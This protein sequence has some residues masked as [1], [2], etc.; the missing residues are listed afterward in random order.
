M[1]VQRILPLLLAIIVAC[2][3][4]IA[5]ACPFCD[6]LPRTLSDDLE[7]SSAAVVAHPEAVSTEP[8]GIRVY[9]M[10]ITDVLKGAPALKNSVV[11]VTSAREIS[12]AKNFWLVG[13]G[14]DRLQ[15]FP[16]TA[17]TS[18]G[19][20]YLR[21]LS[22]LPESGPQRLEY[23]LRF[24]QHTEDFIAADA[25]NEFAE[26]S[27]KDIKG[28]GD[29]LSR[30]WVIAQLRDTAVPLHRRR[31]CWTFLSQCGTAQDT[32]LFDDALRKRRSDPSFNPGMDAAISCFISLGGEQA[33][34]RIEQDFL[35]NP[36]TKES[37]CFS[38][39]SAIRVHGTEL[40]VIP[41]ER[42]ATALRHLLARPELADLVIPD[43]SRWGDWSAIDRMVE[44]FQ[45]STEETALLKP[46]AVRYLKTCPLPD[47]TAALEKL[48]AIDGNAVQVA[49]ASMRFNLGRASLP[50]PPPDLDE[51]TLNAN[52]LRAPEV[53][54]QS[55][56]Q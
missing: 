31:L 56:G 51:P 8:D 39:V 21:G 38:A 30:D 53:A 19:I 44:L 27:L 14:D 32:G 36:A 15:W 43:L 16:P 34:A 29:K 54:D 6:S 20:A 35:A 46:A 7:E 50:V 13:Y 45:I 17:I 22:G 41:R 5:P 2:W 3:A 52:D 48:R 42:L 37:D 9:R 11:N 26:S 40:N 1:P 49:E 12:S 10:R 4:A 47:A 18:E 25:Y 55:Q 23:F 33:L 28:L 24:L